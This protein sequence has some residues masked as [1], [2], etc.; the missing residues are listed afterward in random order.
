MFAFHNTSLVYGQLFI[1][2]TIT[3][4]QLIQSL[5]GEGVVISNVFINCP[6]SAYAQFDGEDCN[7]KIKKGLIMTTGHAEGALG[8]NTFDGEDN[9]ID[10]GGTNDPDLDMVISDTTYNACAIEFDIEV[11]SD[12][13]RFNYIFASEE[14]PEYVCSKFNDVFAFYISGPDIPVPQNI[15]LIPGTDFP[16]SI[17]SINSGFAGPNSVPGGCISLDFNNYYQYNGLGGV[18]LQ[19]T[20]DYYIQYDGFTTVL[21]AK[22][23]VKPCE[24]YHL[25]LVIADVQ[26]YRFDSAVFIEAESFTTDPITLTSTT[27]H[28]AEGFE[29]VIEGC[30]NGLFTF[31]LPAPVSETLIIYYTVSGTAINGTD[32]TNVADSIMILPGDSTALLTIE[33]IQ[34]GIEE[35]PETLTLQITAVNNCT[36]G[37]L[38]NASLD[39]IDNITALAQPQSITNC[40][41]EEVQ[42]AGS[43]GL[44]CEW[45]PVDFLDN[46]NSCSPISKP[47]NSINYTFYARLGLCVDSAEVSILIDDNFMPEVP[48]EYVVCK[49]ESVTLSASGGTAYNWL[50]AGILSCDDCPAPVYIA[51]DDMDFTVQVFDVNDC[52]SEFNVKVIAQNGDL[53]LVSDTVYAC[54]GSSLQ[55]DIPQNFDTYLWEPQTGLSCNDCPNPIVEVEQEQVYTLTVSQGDCQQTVSKTILIDGEIIIDAG[56][57]II[58]C[59]QIDNVLLGSP[60][61]PDYVYEWTPSDGLNDASLAQPTLNLQV[62][63]GESI[64]QTYY[65]TASNSNNNCTANDSIFVNLQST[66]DLT[67]QAPDTVFAGN[68]FD[69]TIIDPQNNTEYT[70]YEENND[71]I[72]I[73]ET[74]TDYIFETTSY[75]ITAITQAGCDTSIQITVFVKTLPEI[76]VPSAFSPNNDGINDYFQLFPDN[77][78]VEILLFEV[79]NRWGNKIFDFEQTAT[80]VWNGEYGNIPQPLG[81]YVYQIRYRLPNGK[82]L[83]EGKY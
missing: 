8:P 44:T 60:G 3:G 37:S 22:S 54:A 2:N 58:A 16:V 62:N 53:G 65:L 42:L 49:G 52:M 29:Q 10:N 69:M 67:I 55:F 25:K 6:D 59:N 73:G 13:L 27:S 50:P 76:L 51:N 17:N 78:E 61:F 14:Y 19:S 46:P 43:G 45:L 77:N 1:D 31:G 72:K 20:D 30:V 40:A 7:V 4:E 70:W 48:D 82:K 26:D 66:P 39:I 75:Q 79:Y 57:D 74:F 36:F 24:A 47:D 5:A 71:V 32:F 34:D 23:A 33:A 21:E 18:G 28:A 68:E 56:A 15:A 83:F 12:T 81:V 38:A 80:K 64:E 35:G 9:S 63:S 41:G 11:A